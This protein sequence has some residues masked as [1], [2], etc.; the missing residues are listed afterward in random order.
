MPLVQYVLTSDGKR[1][2][3]HIL[4]SGAVPMLSAPQ[5]DVI[6]GEIIDAQ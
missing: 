2:M 4:A 1:V 6:E 3:D 5:N